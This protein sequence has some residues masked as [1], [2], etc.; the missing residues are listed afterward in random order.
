MAVDEPRRHRGREGEE[1]GNP[2]RGLPSDSA[3]C[4]VRA[5]EGRAVSPLTARISMRIDGAQGTGRPAHLQILKSLGFPPH[6]P[7]PHIS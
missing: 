5:G 1:V 6:L 7:S 2:G 4:V 3:F